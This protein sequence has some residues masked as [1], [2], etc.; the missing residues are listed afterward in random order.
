MMQASV[1]GAV[2]H[3]LKAVAAA[4][5]DDSAKVMAKMKE[6]PV[7]DF[8]TKNAKIREDGQVMREVYVLQTKTPAESKGEWDLSKVVA[9]IPANEAFQPAS[10]A[11][12]LVK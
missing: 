5:T 10:K 2:S 4:G 1:Y 8:M 12:P 11:C 7:N 6:L 3:Y 9:T